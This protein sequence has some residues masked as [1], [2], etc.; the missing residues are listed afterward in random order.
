MVLR[1]GHNDVVDPD[2]IEKKLDESL[3]KLIGKDQSEGD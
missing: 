3:A 2:T 1:F